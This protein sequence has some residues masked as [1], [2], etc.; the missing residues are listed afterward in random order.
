MAV[1]LE[2][3]II[4]PVLLILIAGWFMRLVDVPFW[5]LDTDLAYIHGEPLLKGGDGYYYLDLARD[6]LAGNYHQTEQLGRVS[7]TLTR[8][9]Y[10]PLPTVL[11][12]W[13][14]K[15]HAISLRLSATL[16][17]PLLG[18]LLALPLF[19]LGRY[20][21][22]AI[23]GV[24]AALLGICSPFYLQ[25]S[26][27]AW[28]DTDILNTT[29][30][31]ALCY[32][33]LR[34]TFAKQKQGGS[35]LLVA[36][37]VYFLF[38]WWWDQA[39]TQITLI[40]VTLG[41]LGWFIRRPKG[42]EL[43]WFLGCN[44]VALVGAILLKGGEAFARIP[45]RALDIIFFLNANALDDFPNP[46]LSISELSV[47]SFTKIIESTTGDGITFTLAVV[48]LGLLF[49]KQPKGC[50][51]LAPIIFIACL[52]FSALRFLIFL[53]PVLALGNGYLISTMWHTWG[54]RFPK[55]LKFALFF[56]VILMAASSVFHN[57]ATV[58]PSYS[59][60][61]V[62]A[63]EEIKTLTPANAIIWSWWDIGHL[64]RYWSQR[65]VISDGHVDF[66]VLYTYLPLT[67][68]NRR[69]AANF[70][71][72]Y[73]KHGQAG[74]TQVFLAANGDKHAGMTLV[75][76]IMAAGPVKARQILA[77]TKLQT[78]PSL[79]TTTQW[80][81]FFFPTATPPIFL[82]IPGFVNNNVY[83]WFWYGSWNF[84]KQGGIHPNF[85]QRKF[86]PENA[87]NTT[88]KADIDSENGVLMLQNRSIPLKTIAMITNSGL[89]QQHYNKNGYIL[90]R[91]KD[92]DFEIVTDKLVV[93]SVYGQL[94]LLQ[95]ANIEDYFQLVKKS[96][97]KNQLWKVLPDPLH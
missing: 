55:L 48:G 96:G 37:V 9:P 8:E 6:L 23:M 35:F 18:P 12:A 90:L 51:F 26:S 44:G 77:T 79:T 34:F 76:R 42:N 71:R 22:G 83:W 70:M 54:E 65:Q 21:G 2:F 80:F 58:V 68:N 60:E 61:V 63:I 52:G 47:P 36:T 33:F 92:L 11:I 25:R 49:Y 5:Q 31:L 29:L 82:Y 89:H 56:I 74:M 30:L 19:A 53:S 57:T 1:K 69:L 91:Y 75:K 17:G 93:E 73:V 43:G 81:D 38:L 10:P 15:A 85:L 20:F 3:R 39:F 62:A 66:D 45:E 14:A 7:H 95:H 41:L 84:G 67:V 88:K 86:G 28:F 4:A 27:F 72:F 59:S 50:L 16:M 87:D 32:C 13:L 24:T 46:A 97:I 94:F 64:I 78:L 40:F